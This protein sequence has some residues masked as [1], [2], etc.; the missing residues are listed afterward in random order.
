MFDPQKTQSL[1]LKEYNHLDYLWGENAH[2]DIYRPVV[3]FA[4]SHC[5]RD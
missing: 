1:E 3:D 4:L 2:R 5:P